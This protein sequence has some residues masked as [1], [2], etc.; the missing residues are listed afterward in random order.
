MQQV[1]EQD[2]AELL[3]SEMDWKQR[4]LLEELAPETLTV[5]TG[6]RL[7]LEYAPDK[8]PTLSVRL[9]EVFGWLETPRLAGGRVAVLV[10]LLGPNYRPVQV[11][12]DLASFWRS[13]Y[14]E[15]R[16]DLR[17][18]YPKHAWPED[19]LTATPVAKG[20]PRR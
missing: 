13:A 8:Q 18:R 7:R 5:P 15:V 16:K 9:Q 6:N 14:F 4:K 10:E 20:R 17:V 1:K 3:L 11:T 12:S 2:L 19:P